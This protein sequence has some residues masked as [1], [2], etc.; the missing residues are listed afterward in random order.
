[1]KALDLF[2]AARPLLHLPVWTVYLVCLHYHHRLSGGAFDLFDLGLM[3]C[4]SLLFAGAFYINQVF[5]FESDRINKKI[6]FLQRGL[7]SRRGM[8]A[9][10]LVTSTLAL[11][12]SPI[13]SGLTVTIFIMIVILAYTYS[14]PP[15]RLK[16]RAIGG[17][18]A[19]ML[20]HGWLVSIAVMPEM[21]MHNSGLL[22]WDNPLYFSLA[23]GATYLLTT[24]PDMTGDRATGKR[25]LSVK[26]GSRTVLLIA[27]AML[28]GATALAEADGH[29]AL[30]IVASIAV[31]L[32]AIGLVAT[33]TRVVLLAAKLPLLLLTLAAGYWYPVYL[34]FVV[35]LLSAT[36]IYYQRRFGIAYPR[37]A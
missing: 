20:A 29:H 12:V 21:N 19:N 22:G 33:D 27:L 24:I 8:M 10:F 14:A 3:A 1:M 13:F 32:V 17:L 31:V 16:D 28:V 36:R 4:L 18:A 35:A 26:F 30:T 37:I 25:T 23:V 6:G 5:D 7:I 15:V 9:G 34:L 11:T 2:F